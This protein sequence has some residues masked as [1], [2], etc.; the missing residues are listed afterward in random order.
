MSVLQH[1]VVFARLRVRDAYSGFHPPGPPILLH[2]LT[3]IVA[4]R[5]TA[6]PLLSFA[7]LSQACKNH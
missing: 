3:Q 5:D 1:E 2:L 6:S 7:T 4:G